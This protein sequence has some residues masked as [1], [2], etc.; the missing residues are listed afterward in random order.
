MS[1]AERNKLKRKSIKDKD[2][3]SPGVQKKDGI[4]KTHR[5]KN[6]SN[7][8]ESDTSLD[9]DVENTSPLK[10]E[11]QNGKGKSPRGYHSPSRNSRLT[12]DEDLNSHNSPNSRTRKTPVL[13]SS[14]KN[15]TT[16]EKKNRAINPSAASPELHKPKNKPTPVKKINQNVKSHQGEHIY[17]LNKSSP[18]TH[19]VFCLS[20]AIAVAVIAFLL[21]GDV[22]GGF[23][24]RTESPAI[25]I[26]QEK[27]FRN[28]FTQIQQTHPGLSNRF[29]SICG[30]PI[31]SVIQNPAP[32]QPAVIMIASPPGR[33][34][35]GNEIASQLSKTYPSDTTPIFINSTEYKSEDPD[36]VKMK[37]DT[38][39]A[40]GFERGSKAAVIYRLEELPPPAI[41]IFY[42]Y[43]D[44]E[45]APYKDTV[46]IFTIN[47][48]YQIS[49]NFSTGR[50]Q[51]KVD[52]FLLSKWQGHE[53]LDTDKIAALFSRI[54]NSVAIVNTEYD[55]NPVI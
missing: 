14:N 38:L 34:N 32:T 54:G 22:G 26:Q 13:D 20:C 2:S 4:T 45:N 8:S 31:Q 43:C 29:W 9:I 52:E 21:F 24:R 10:Q 51:E 19:K 37:V 33:S 30:I 44:N 6:R 17:D 49:N 15:L 11:T 12:S 35:Q 18:F 53:D 46:I 16:G 42:K 36:I 28:K 55:P 48:P 50:Q 25:K 41:L 5:S 47:L 39:L 23:T 3:Y 27:E 7:L 1:R 40:N